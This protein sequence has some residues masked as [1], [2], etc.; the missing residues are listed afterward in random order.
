MDRKNL[1]ITFFLISL[2]VFLIIT[3]FVLKE[4]TK[5]DFF[6][7]EK[8]N[9]DYGNKIYYFWIFLGEASKPILIGISILTIILLYWQK[10]KK[11]SLILFFSLILGY[12]LE[13]ILKLWIERSR[14]LIN[15][16]PISEYSFPSGHALMSMILFSLITYFYNNKIKNNF[17]RVLFI[18]GN[19][20]LILLIGFSRIYLRV[21]WFTDVIGGFTLGFAVLNFVLWLFEKKGLKGLTKLKGS[22]KV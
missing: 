14:P 15:L 18:S 19:I 8:I 4:T 20:L 16:I 5:I 2:T 9:L 11:E 17:I 6:I 13:Q 12:V 21:H 22:S 7:Y 1:Y 10:R 3:I